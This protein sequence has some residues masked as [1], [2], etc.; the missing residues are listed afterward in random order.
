MPRPVSRMLLLLFCSTSSPVLRA[1]TS[2]IHLKKIH[3]ELN[4]HTIIFVRTCLDARIAP[5]QFAVKA[6][7][8]WR[9]GEPRGCEEANDDSR[10]GGDRPERPRIGASIVR[11]RRAGTCPGAQCR[12]GRWAAPTRPSR[13]SGGGQGGGGDRGRRHGAP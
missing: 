3:Q 8:S 4:S 6:Y 10:D 5:N 13:A 7:A 11:Q 1:N 2:S 9:H 12:Q